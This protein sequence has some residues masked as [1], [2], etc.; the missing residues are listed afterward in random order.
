MLQNIKADFNCVWDSFDDYPR[1]KRIFFTLTQYGFVAIAVYRYGRW[2]RQFR[3]PI[4][5]QIAR[6]LYFLAK[7]LIE[8]FFGICIDVNSDIGP[9]FFI[10]HFGCIIV[11]G[12]IGS[13]C[14]IGQGVTIGSKGA[15]KSNGWPVIGDNVFIGAGAKIIGAINLGNNV[16]VGANAVVICDVTD[17]SLAVGVP[18]KVRQR[19]A[20]AR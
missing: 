2:A 15:G 17:D 9:G 7:T 18:A 8:I 6:I 5:G 1:A 20:S 10:G 14:S 4:A 3:V 13:K 19:H 16:V 12:K 11:H